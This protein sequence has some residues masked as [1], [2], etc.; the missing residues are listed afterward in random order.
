MDPELVIVG[1]GL[2]GLSL[3]AELAARADGPRLVLV[4][5]RSSWGW[6]RTWCFWARPDDPALALASHTW[7]AWEVVSGGDRVRR[8]AAG[9]V[10]VHLP[11]D[12][13]Y[14]RLLATLRRSPRVRFEQ[15]R[16]DAIV[17]RGDAVDVTTSAGVLRAARAVDTRPPDLAASPPPGERRLLQHF[18]G[19]H[20]RTDVDRFDPGVITLMDFDTG[21]ADAA[22]VN[23]RYV[24]PFSPREALV[25]D[26][27]FGEAPLAAETYRA[28][29]TRWLDAGPGMWSIGREERGILPMSTE[30]FDPRPSPRVYRLGL[31]GGAARPSTGYAFLAVRRSAA[32]LAAHLIDGRPVPR[33]RPWR[34]DLLD[35]VFL[36]WLASTP[37][38]G[39]R[40]FHR[41]FRDVPPG[42]LVRF[43]SD[44]ST[45]W[46]ELRVMLA[47]TPVAGPGMPL[48]A[49]RRL[50]AAP[51]PP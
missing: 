17:D 35:A 16:V 34:V 15:G 9:E 1:A 19:W 48:A 31:A 26:T 11:A 46:D 18:L 29:L 3:A 41:M 36:E 37:E 10:Y 8:S 22:Q 47:V 42:A 4:D 43:L 28:S 2:A 27:W 6:D 50:I 21:A 5:P 30:R 45:W 24:L 38:A 44:R 32:A 20:V 7:G 23:F 39:P 14:A 33:V 40:A 12:R 51:A 25:E 13:V 49:R